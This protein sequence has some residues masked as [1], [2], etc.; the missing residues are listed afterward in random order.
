MSAAAVP[1]PVGRTRAAAPRRSLRLNPTLV[2]G[3]VLLALIVLAGVAAPLIT[4]WD[5]IQQDLTSS[6][7]TPGNGHLLGTDQLGRDVF[8]RLLYAARVE[9]KSVV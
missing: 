2:G 8:A 4:R 7:L 5:P 6:L 3:L 1:G 9:R